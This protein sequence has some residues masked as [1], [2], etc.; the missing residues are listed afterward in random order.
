[1]FMNFLKIL[2]T[3]IVIC[4]LRLKAENKRTFFICTAANSAYY[5]RLI[6]LIGSSHAT[7]FEN[8]HTIAV[9]DLGLSEAEKNYLNSI[10]RVK[11]LDI[12]TTHPDQLKFFYS[13]KEKRTVLGWYAWKPVIIKQALDMF[14]YVLWIDAGTTILRPIGDLFI[15]LKNEGYFLCTIGD[16]IVNGK[17]ARSVRWG[18]TQYAIHLFDLSESLTNWVLDQES[19]MGGVIGASRNHWSYDKFLMPLYE[20]AKDVRNFA[21]DGTAEE[22]G[23]HDQTIMSF[24]AYSQNLTVFKQDRQQILPIRFSHISQGFFITWDQRF[25]DNKTHIFSS[26]DF[27]PNYGKFKKALK[28]KKVLK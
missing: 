6:N 14:P 25:V 20:L 10:K 11:V 4:S 1:M 26:R 28:Y 8:L 21:D 12:K 18:A 23:R 5:S 15:H 17:Y 19:I 9:F 24:L 27:M 3:F 22:Y 7:N 16:D 2:I 13:A